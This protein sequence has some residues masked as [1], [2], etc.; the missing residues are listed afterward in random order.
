MIP[1]ACFHH[2][3]GQVCASALDV[4]RRIPF[5]IGR[6]PALLGLHLVLVF[7]RVSSGEGGHCEA[8]VIE[9]VRPADDG[10]PERLTLQMV[11]AWEPHNPRRVDQARVAFIEGREAALEVGPGGK[12]AA[13]LQE[14]NQVKAPGACL[15]DD[16]RLDWERARQRRAVEVNDR[17]H[18]RGHI[19]RPASLAIRAVDR[20]E[21]AGAALDLDYEPFLDGQVAQAPVP[22]LGQVAA[23][24][25]LAEDLEAD[26][27]IVLAGKQRQEPLRL[28]PIGFV[29]WSCSSRTM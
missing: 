17:R 4:A 20:I 24:A 8:G 26:Q 5:Y 7:P 13:R 3:A 22:I 2:Q 6:R 10:R 25:G 28:F 11:K 18:G 29:H 27:G 9:G 12:V 23:V 15:D 16:M 14:P 21:D 19:R 1:L